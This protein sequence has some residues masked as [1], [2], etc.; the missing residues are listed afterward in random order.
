[1]EPSAAAVLTETP[2]YSS[3]VK[4]VDQIKRVNSIN[5]Y[6]TTKY[7]PNVMVPTEILFGPVPSASDK[8]EDGD[9]VVAVDMEYERVLLECET[10]YSDENND[11]EMSKGQENVELV[12][13]V[14]FMTTSSSPLSLFQESAFAPGDAILECYSAW[15]RRDMAA[16]AACFEEANLSYQDSLYFGTITQ[17]QHLQHHFEQEAKALPLDAQLVLDHIAEDPAT[18]HAAT[19]WHVETKE[20]IV[21]PLTKGVSFYT[22][23]TNS[24]NNGTSKIRS[25]FRVSEMLVKT[26]KELA[27]ILVTSASLLLR[28]TQSGTSNNAQIVADKQTAASLSSVNIIEE[29]FEA[30]NR[31][32]VEAALDC[33]VENC[34]LRTEDSVF[35]GTFRGKKSLR[36]H[37]ENNAQILPASCKIVLDQVAIDPVNGNIG[38]KWHLE[39]APGVLIPN[40]RGCSM[41]TTDSESG[42]LRTGLDITEAPLKVPRQALPLLSRSVGLLLFGRASR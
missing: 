33:F 16:A 5:A 1:L 6:D 13:G 19:E 35:V 22:T 32:D 38:T 17:S 12:P 10:D 8:E 23:T 30:W 15:N 28:I 3:I 7:G 24:T 27:H 26:P 34:T 9:D 14:D 20:G 2:R 18:G 39:L 11:I 25:G 41:Y 36:K 29:F 4:S 37:L 40:L 42:L 21:V 31:R